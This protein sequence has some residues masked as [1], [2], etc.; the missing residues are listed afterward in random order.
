[1]SE[2]LAGRAGLVPKTLADACRR[3]PARTAWL[4]ALPAALRELE[5]RWSLT[6]GVP[7]TQ[8]SAAWVAPVSR[9]DGTP[10]VLKVGMPHM[11]AE[12]EIDGLRVWNGN[13]TALLLEADE[14]LGAMLLE[15]CEPGTT[16]R[17]EVESEQDRVIAGLLRR[18][19]Q[20]PVPPHVFR[21]LSTMTKYW[22][23]ETRSHA[24]AWPDP[25]LVRHGLELFDELP[26]TATRDVLLATDLHAGN[27]L[28]SRRE[29]W[30]V[31]DPKPF[32]GDP[33]Y[34]ATQHLFNC[35]ERLRTDADGTIRRVADLLDVEA[36]R[37]RAWMF[38]RA[39]AEPRDDWREDWRMDFARAIAG[40]RG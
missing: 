6:L 23:D 35:E 15:R 13:P 18:L 34:D 8:A 3:S 19:W 28:R 38:A 1:M 30:L 36:V 5:R 31:I 11:E 37:V 10:A 14:A 2:S 7:F 27:V 40:R 4:E 33:A 12:Q 24:E 29:P 21:L 16:L 39:A 9:A 25:G 17:E 20:A 22:S 26:R 32:V